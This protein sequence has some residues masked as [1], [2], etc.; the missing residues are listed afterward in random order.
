MNRPISRRTVLR[1]LGIALALPW[2]EVMAPRS[3]LSA[4]SARAGEIRKEAP[5]RLAFFYVPNGIHMPDWTPAREGAGFDLPPTLKPLEPFQRDF[6]VLSGLT[7]D[8]ARPNGDGAGDHARAA[9][10]F[11][12]GCQPRKTHGADIKAGISVDQVAAGRVA[13]TTRFPSLELGCDRGAQAGN[14]D[15]G[16]S[17]AYS[18]NISWKT[19]ST[20]MA[21]EIDPRLLFERLFPS[22]AKVEAAESRARREKHRKSVLDFVEE[23]AT[24]LR[25]KLGATD[26]RKLDEYFT[27]IREIES[28]V[29]RSEQEALAELKD[30]AK[31]KPP[32]VVARPDGIPKDYAEHMRLLCDI[33]A[34]AFQANLTRVATF[35]LANEGSNRSY[36]FVGAPEGHHD[37]SH[38]GNNKE[39]QSKIAKINRFHV[40]SFAYFLGKLKG[41]GDGDGTLL[42]NCMIVYGSAIGDGNAHNH[43]ELPI[44]LAGRGA[45]T[46]EPGRHVR[47]PRNTPLNNL[48]LSLL[49]RMEATTDS[50]GDSTGR[51]ARLAS[52]TKSF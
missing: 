21:K 41:I 34:I 49:D 44:L 47:Y 5:P 9:A 20:P 28:R 42:D 29:D 48:Y 16:Y 6:L 11:L 45:G 43:D 7:A 26:Q 1:G 46:I 4:S 15:S 18:A 32:A 30:N 52:E 40:E 25:K 17:C 19:P 38:H 8:K 37:L 22:Y 35:M 50:L 33:L 51:L 31:E 14:C 12:T 36:G 2:L 13:H 24:Q 39:K 10:A 23:D 27:A 3:A